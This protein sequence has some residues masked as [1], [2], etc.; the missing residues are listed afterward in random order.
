MRVSVCVFAYVCVCNMYVCVC[1]FVCDYFFKL[2]L[3]A[4]AFQQADVHNS[5]NTKD[6]L[7][8]TIPG[9]LHSSDL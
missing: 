7:P 8:Y 6:E 5:T 4:S 9:G 1:V 3:Q 2:Y